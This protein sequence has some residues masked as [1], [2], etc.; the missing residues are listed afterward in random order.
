MKTQ[1][2]RQAGGNA[3]FPSLFLLPRLRAW[4]P[5][6]QSYENEKVLPILEQASE[7]RNGTILLKRRHFSSPAYGLIIMWAEIMRNGTDGPRYHN[8]R[9]ASSSFLLQTAH[10]V[11][12]CCWDSKRREVVFAFNSAQ[13]PRGST[14]ASRDASRLAFVCHLLA[15]NWAEQ[16]RTRAATSSPSCQSADCDQP[17]HGDWGSAPFAAENTNHRQ[18]KG[19]SHA[20]HFTHLSSLIQFHS[21][22][23]A[24]SESL[25]RP[26][27]YEHGWTRYSRGSQNWYSELSAASESW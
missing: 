1:T 7:Q 16:R 2:G 5:G 25:S 14:R 17:H 21:V 27:H 9:C 19:H 22:L 24:C 10:H 18:W 23:S 13:E 11:R 20:S 26:A 6:R 4:H 3:Y 12:Y 15:L 8:N